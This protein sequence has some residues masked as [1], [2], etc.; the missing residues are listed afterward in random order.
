MAIGDRIRNV[1]PG[2]RWLVVVAHPDDESF[3]CG[4]SI[5]HAVAGGAEV[6]IVCATRGEAGVPATELIPDVSLGTVR[7]VELREAGAAL[8]ARRVDVLDY[9][10]SDFDGDLPVGSLCAAPQDALAARIASYVTEIEPTVLLVPDAS[11]GHRDHRRMQEAAHEAAEQAVD[12]DVEVWELCIP[13]A[14]MR[15]W[16][17][18]MQSLKPDTAY[19]ALDPATL[20]R[21]DGDIVLTL[22]VAHVLDRR[23]AAMACHRSQASPF[24]GLSPELRHAFLTTD[25][26]A[27]GSDA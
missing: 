8:G 27:R 16:L 1:G 5:A 24:D 18:E 23:E 21:P 20:G 9:L 17:V 14:L 7:E 6:T 19:H 13:N 3:G 2:D 25:H 11:D 15:R 10:D 22:D 4:S 26:F 12:V